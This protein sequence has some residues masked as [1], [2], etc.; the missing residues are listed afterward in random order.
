MNVKGLVLALCLGSVLLA[1]CS[2]DPSVKAPS[3]LT[4]IREANQVNLNWRDNSDNEAGFAIFRKIESETGFTR[5]QQTPPNTETY[6]DRNVTASGRYVYEVRAFAANGSESTP[7]IAEGVE[8]TVLS[9]PSGLTATA[10]E[11][12]I[13]LSWTDTSDNEEGFSV[14]RRLETDAAFPADALASVAADVTTYSDTSISAGTNYVYQVVAFAGSSVSEASNVSNPAATTGPNPNPEPTGPV[15]NSLSAPE[16]DTTYALGARIRLAWS[17]AEQNTLTELRLERVDGAPVTLSGT[18]ATSASVT[19][20]NIAGTFTYRLTATNA[21]GTTTKDIQIS[22]GTP[23]GVGDLSVAESGSDY[24]LTWTMTGTGPFT[25][26]VEYELDLSDENGIN[27]KTFTY[28]NIPVTVENGV[29][30]GRV[31]QPVDDNGNLVSLEQIQS[32]VLIVNSDFGSTP[33]A[34]IGATE[35][36]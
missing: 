25:F 29:Y 32:R 5:I 16:N 27:F 34:T 19:L 1:G 15:I 35:R 10:G 18:T 11:N 2:G 20:P 8:V 22:T 24:L 36:F 7:A 17:I 31:T 23:P 33:G 9:A 30:T 13:D 28:R 26:D 6:T 3:S 21:G 4:A 12:K 14:F